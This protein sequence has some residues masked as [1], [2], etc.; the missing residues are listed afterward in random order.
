MAAVIIGRDCYT[1][2]S[3]QEEGCGGAV[4]GSSDS[5]GAFPA[6]D[7]V[8]PGDE[9]ATIRPSASGSIL[10]WKPR[11]GGPTSQVSRRSPYPAIVQG[12]TFNE[13]GLLA[14]T[15]SFIRPGLARQCEV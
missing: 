11:H 6:T 13:A 12:L 10:I 8:T 3:P 5:T 15:G 2:S 14:K 1:V 7:P 9:A 4:Y